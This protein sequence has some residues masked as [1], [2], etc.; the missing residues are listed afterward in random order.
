MA[1]TAKNY[2]SAVTAHGPTDIWVDIAVP[3][4]SAQMTLYTDGTP[5]AT[6]NP[7]A[8]HVGMLKT[9]AEVS[10]SAQIQ[11]KT[12]D[13]LTT[14]YA[15]NLLTSEAL[16]K[17]DWLQILDTQLINKLSLGGTRTTPSGKEVITF[18]SLS[19][20]T[21]TVGAAIWALVAD[22][23]KFAV[24]QIYKC[25]NKSGWKAVLNRKEDAAGDL[26]LTGV[27][28][29]SRATEDQVCALWKQV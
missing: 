29:T 19:T 2:D 1:G 14:P 21:Y 27:A 23:T 20:V 22:A 28:I 12:S 18:G 11:E 13:N 25:Y 26:E 7:S 15:V 3:G 24:F 16:I 17:G 9:G 5:D 6:A 10:I 4:A 8:R